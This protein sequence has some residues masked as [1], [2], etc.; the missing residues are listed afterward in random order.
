VVPDR[1]REEI[2]YSVRYANITIIEGLGA[3]QYDIG[4][5]A[6]RVAEVVLRGE[7]AVFPVGAHNSRYGVALSLPASSEV[8]AYA[9][10]SGR[11]GRTRRRALWSVVPRP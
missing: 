7:R 6:G 11:K 5:V 1:F 3:S 9:R 8:P 10:C 2:E 4:M